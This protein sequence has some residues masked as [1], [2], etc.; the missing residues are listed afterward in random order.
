MKKPSVLLLLFALAALIGN[1]CAFEYN[2]T[3]SFDQMWL[4]TYMG[5]SGLMSGR[6][7][8]S[9]A[10]VSVA[11]CF[12]A[13]VLIYMLGYGLQLENV[14]RFAKS[15]FYHVTASAIMIV[16][17]SVVLDG[18]LQYTVNNVIGTESVAI[19]KGQEFKIF[20][21]SGGPI[22]YIYCKVDE[23]AKE[24]EDC[25]T[26]TYSANLATERKAS[27]C[28]S[29]KGIPIYCGDWSMH[30]E[31]EGNH[32]TGYKITP[33]LVNLYGQK[34]V[35]NYLAENMLRVFLP[36]GLLLRVFP[37][38]RGIGGLFIAIALGFYF[39]FPVVYLV[40]DPSFVKRVKADIPDGSAD[41]SFSCYPGFKGSAAI[42]TIPSFDTGSSGATSCNN[43][44]ELLTKVTINMMF[45]PFVALATTLIFIRMAASLLGGDSGDIMRM[46]SKVI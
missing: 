45:Y 36:L 33:I 25:Y 2:S 4:E 40:N 28:A 3:S 35:L 44:T 15:E 26:K 34:A 9:I 7:W 22:S 1:L 18:T 23:S 41:P 30:D 19:C 46:I 31:V 6:D 39:V 24:L 43:V 42:L 10:M 16:T 8:Q 32:L 5:K 12:F 20:E 17:M 11:A 37:M 38:L 29:I 21:Y 13:N 14:K 27:T